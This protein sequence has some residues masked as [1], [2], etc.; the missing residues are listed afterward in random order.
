[1]TKEAHLKVVPIQEINMITRLRGS[2]SQPPHPTPKGFHWVLVCKDCRIC[3]CFE[4]IAMMVKFSPC[5]ELILHHWVNTGKNS[6]FNFWYFRQSP[7]M[8]QGAIDI[9][10][11]SGQR[12]I[13]IHEPWFWYNDYCNIMLYIKH[14]GNIRFIF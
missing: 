6:E 12:Y 1:M 14:V 10:P 7:K 3:F 4:C 13:F 9:E 2:S 8:Y 5:Y 11:Y